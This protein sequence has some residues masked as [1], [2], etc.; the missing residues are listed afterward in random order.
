MHNKFFP[1]FFSLLIFVASG[2][3]ITFPLAFHLGDMSVGIGDELVISWIQNWVIHILQT[4]NILS[5][6]E[7]NTYFPY[8]NTLAYSDLFL[9]SS[10]LAFIPF[11]I[12]KEPIVIFNFTLLSSLI[13]LGFSIY[14]LSFYLTKNFLPSLLA[15]ILVIYSPAVL[16]K[17]THVQILAIFWVP[18]SVLFYLIFIY[19]GKTRYLVISL[20]FFLLQTYNSFLPG[21]F[22]IFSLLIISMY[23][24]LYKESLMLKLLTKKTIGLFVLTSV[25]LLPVVLPYYQVSNEFNY[26][27]DI[28]ETI[29]F[30]LQPEDFFYP[31]V[32]T[33]LQDY[34]LAIP[35][36]QQAPERYFKP[37]YIGFVFS[38]LSSIA[39]FYCIK[40]FRR[41]DAVINSFISIAFVG[42]ILSLGSA[43]HLGRQTIHDPFPIP[44]PYAL[45][46]YLL[47]GFQGFRNSARWEMLFIL[48]MAVAIA[49]VLSQLLKRFSFKSRIA[50]YLLFILLVVAEFKFP[51]TLVNIPQ[52]KEFPSVYSW[53]N[54]TPANTSVI[55]MPAYNWNMTYPQEEILRQYFSTTNFRRTVN[56]Y[57]G[58]SP[59]P[60][61]NLLEKL[62]SDFPSEETLKSIKNLGVTYIIIDKRMYDL[63]FEEGKTEFDGQFVINRLK[64]CPSL[65]FVGK[66]EEYYIFKF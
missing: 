54:T 27:R 6:F 57:S 53:L 44:L 39:I 11:Q 41:K 14:L 31:S 64:Q 22:I 33:R 38:L 50:V 21:Y 24:F 40:F 26:T 56:G 30:A 3:Y 35:F 66:R 46:Y 7:A 16:D 52:T 5:L 59:P 49:I 42:G 48:C 18:L 2:I 32:H 55:F 51:I 13:L 47:P 63:E 8:H 20:L 4:G 65:T 36:N 12:M 43:L 45:F 19:S 29:H 10:I 15:G 25:L 23:F 60:W 34:L 62:R 37:G 9:T 28:R 1:A 61:Q 17:S 58:F